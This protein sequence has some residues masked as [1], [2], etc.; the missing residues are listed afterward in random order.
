MYFLNIKIKSYHKK[1]DL[2]RRF[3]G[4]IKNFNGE[5]NELGALSLV[6]FEFAEAWTERFKSPCSPAR[7]I[8]ERS[9]EYKLWDVTDQ[10]HGWQFWHHTR[11]RKRKIRSRRSC[12]LHKERSF[13][14]IL[15]I[16]IFWIRESVNSLC[17][18]F[19]ACSLFISLNVQIGTL[20][21]VG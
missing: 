6:T 13:G 4:Y 14:D 16:W 2:V 20:R 3:F 10:T 1:H 17:P 15:L 7:R 11:R 5:S 19:E 21:D 8:L 9:T 12:I 18:V